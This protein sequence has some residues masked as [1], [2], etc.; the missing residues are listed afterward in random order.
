M[1]I[2]VRIEPVIVD[3]DHD[4]SGFYEEILRYGTVIYK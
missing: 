3:E 2:D 4:P 1:D